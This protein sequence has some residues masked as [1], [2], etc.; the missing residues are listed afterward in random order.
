MTIKQN[1]QTKKESKF[2]NKTGSHWAT[3]NLSTQDAEASGFL[4][5]RPARATQRNP[6]SEKQIKWRL[7]RELSG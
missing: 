1:K 6:V 5:S 3:F 2:K 4:S 7:K